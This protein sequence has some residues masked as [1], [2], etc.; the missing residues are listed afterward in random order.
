MQG[1][2]KLAKNGDE[3]SNQVDVI[4]NNKGKLIIIQFFMNEKPNK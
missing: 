2:V 1:N 4:F 3:K